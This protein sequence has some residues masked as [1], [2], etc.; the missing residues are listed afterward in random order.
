MSS[1]E[2]EIKFTITDRRLLARKLRA[3]GFHVLHTRT[4]EFNTLYDFMT[5]QGGELR[6]RGELLRLRRYGSDWTFTFK[7]K[8]ELAK[9]KS[10][11]EQELNVSDGVV[12][13]KI[14]RSLGFVPTFQ[15]EKYRTVWSDGHGD[16][17][18]DETPIGDIGEIE[19]AA[20]WIDR[21]AKKLGISQTDYSTAS[22][23]TLFFDWKK[24][25][26]NKAMNMTWKAMGMKRK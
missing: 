17:M 12:M 21:T 8:A 18:M 23:A 7:G 11:I 16:V 9:H 2:V 22:Y 3:G 20:K 19:G 25:T 26:G 24:R 14:L 4:H 10:R 5:P 13:D 6:S 1:R 15:Y